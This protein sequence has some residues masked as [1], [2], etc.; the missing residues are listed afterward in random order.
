MSKNQAAVCGCL[1]AWLH[2]TGCIRKYHFHNLKKRKVI[3][4]IYFQHK[5][6][7]TV[8][9]AVD[10]KVLLVQ[11]FS[12]NLFANCAGFQTFPSYCVW[13][14]PC[15][16][17]RKIND[18]VFACRNVSALLSHPTF[19]LFFYSIVTDYFFL[20]CLLCKMNGSSCTESLPLEQVL[21]CVV[22]VRVGNGNLSGLLFPFCQKWLNVPFQH[23]LHY[24]SN[25]ENY[26]FGDFV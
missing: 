2:E 17:P 5:P 23:L 18:S 4:L 7:L 21:C 12:S 11:V 20:C 10:R 26:I 14:G 19:P 9:C 16:T 1:K 22:F 24:F 8:C 3:V 6:A 13:L 15:F 25:R